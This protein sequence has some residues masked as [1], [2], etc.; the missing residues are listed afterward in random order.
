MNFFDIPVGDEQEPDNRVVIDVFNTDDWC[1][2]D[3]NGQLVEDNFVSYNQ[4]MA[5]AIDNDY[6]VVDTINI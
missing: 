6:E 4:A 3:A 2:H 1:I 5:W